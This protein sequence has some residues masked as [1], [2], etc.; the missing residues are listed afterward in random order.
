LLEEREDEDSA[1]AVKA[2]D[3]LQ[4]PAARVVAEGHQRAELATGSDAFR[5]P[6]HSGKSRFPLRPTG[7]GNLRDRKP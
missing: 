5:Q 4:G 1:P 7:Q 6:S 2:H 3:R